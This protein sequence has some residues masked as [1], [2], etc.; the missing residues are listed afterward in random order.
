MT[1]DC[2]C[3]ACQLCEPIPENCK[4]GLSIK[5]NLFQFLKYAD[6]TKEDLQ[7]SLKHWVDNL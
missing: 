3:R 1:K 4:R 5:L 6:T 2:F 7:N